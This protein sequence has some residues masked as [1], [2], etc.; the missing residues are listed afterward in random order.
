MSELGE[1]VLR[2][3]L[4]GAGATAFLDLFNL[5]KSVL[6]RGPKPDMRL[7]GRWIGYFPRGQFVHQSV[8]KAVPV[9]G[10]NALG[11]IAHY[12][13]GIAF[14]GVGVLAWGLEWAR[15]PTFPPALT[16]GVVSVVAPFFVMQPGMGLGVFASRAPN[17]TEARLRALLNHSVFGVGLYV[18]AMIVAALLP[19]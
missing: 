12:A 14:A 8:A 5:V 15:H 16:V 9:A 11:W 4:I 3:G 2:S 13:I 10:E 18:A 7:I 1:I 17:P 19:A 6:L